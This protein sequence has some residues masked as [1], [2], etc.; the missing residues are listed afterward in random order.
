MVEICQF[1]VSSV[2]INFLRYDYLQ[3]IKTTNCL[4]GF[5]LTAVPIFSLPQES[6]V[7][8]VQTAG[9]VVDVYFAQRFGATAILSSLGITTIRIWT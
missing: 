5:P 3:T 1:F 4:Y 2:S 9:A 6:M 7:Q 8:L